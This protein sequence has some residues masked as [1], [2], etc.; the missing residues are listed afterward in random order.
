MRLDR[1]DMLCNLRTCRV[2][3]CPPHIVVK[4]EQTD[5]VGVTNNLMI[6]I[7]I[8]TSTDTKVGGSSNP[9]GSL[10]AR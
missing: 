4:H 6:G 5:L 9:L 7:A 1:V 10:I 3:E 2:T 8:S